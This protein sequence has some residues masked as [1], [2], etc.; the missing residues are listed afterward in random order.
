L[1]S[2]CSLAFGVIFESAQGP[3]V[4]TINI[5]KEP[6]SCSFQI[7]TIRFESDKQQRIHYKSRAFESI[8]SVA[9]FCPKHPDSRLL[10]NAQQLKGKASWDK[11]K[12]K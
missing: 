4:L 11:F 6:P 10:Q 5:G 12:F 8:M 3:G 1:L 9:S 2:S 7:G